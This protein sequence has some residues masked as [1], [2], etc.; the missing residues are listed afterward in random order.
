M[1]NESIKY[2]VR[3]TIKEYGRL[4]ILL[5]NAGVLAWKPLRQQTFEEIEAQVRVNFEG[6]IKITKEFLPYIT[7]SIINIGSGA[8]K[9]PFP[10]LTTYCATKYGLR[11]FTQ[12]LAFEERH[13]RIYAVNPGMT[14]TRMTNYQGVPPEKVSKVILNTAKGLYNLPSGSDVDVWRYI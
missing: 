12:S 3:G 8:G 2:L 13:L 14:A 10:D 7:D 6:L 9:S 5:N 1:D 4:D 11:G